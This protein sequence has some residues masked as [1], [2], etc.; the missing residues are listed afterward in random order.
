MEDVFP[1]DIENC[2]GNEEATDAHPDT[3][4][5]GGDHEGY[6]KIRKQGRH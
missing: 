3:V 5:K 4:R 1:K 2:W 6:D